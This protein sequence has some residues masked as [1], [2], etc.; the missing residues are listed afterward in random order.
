MTDHE[1]PRVTE[2]SA[3]SPRLLRRHLIT[4]DPS[5]PL[6]LLSLSANPSTTKPPLLLAHNLLSSTPSTLNCCRPAIASSLHRQP[7]TAS[8]T[9]LIYSRQPLFVDLPDHTRALPPLDNPHTT[10]TPTSTAIMR[11]NSISSVSSTSS[12]AP[13]AEPE[14]TMQIFVKNLSGDSKHLTSSP[15]PLNPKLTTLQPSP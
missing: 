10:H 7:V 8:P 3:C 4:D 5:R 11:S 12:R 15:N 13:S 9:P 14:E 1:S 6:L 2:P